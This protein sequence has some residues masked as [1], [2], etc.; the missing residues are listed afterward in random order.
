MNTV[1]QPETVVYPEVIARP[2]EK[3]AQYSFQIPP[4]DVVV[5][6]DDFHG[7]ET[8]A[9]EPEPAC[10]RQRIYVRLAGIANCLQVL[11]VLR[12]DLQHSVTADAD[13]LTLSVQVLRLDHH[14]R[15]PGQLPVKSRNMAFPA[16]YPVH[17][18][19]RHILQRESVLMAVD[20]GDGG[21]YVLALQTYFRNQLIAE[22]HVAL[23]PA[24]G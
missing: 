23:D 16:S 13:S 2:H 24:G 18:G 19:V 10:S 14:M 11:R 15:K 4:K 17:L 12:R 7:I 8:A 1:R 21:H 22:E 3:N 5:K 20:L 9:Y 6:P